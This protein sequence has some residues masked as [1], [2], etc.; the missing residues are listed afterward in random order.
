[1]QQVS[2]ALPIP[3]LIPKAFRNQRDDSQSPYRHGMQEADRVR[4]KQEYSI[5]KEGRRLIIF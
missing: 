5:G 3:Q 4:P 1:M 2:E